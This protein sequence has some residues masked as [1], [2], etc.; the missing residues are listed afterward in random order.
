[1][2]KAAAGPAAL[3]DGPRNID[4]GMELYLYAHSKE[5]EEEVMHDCLL[6][7]RCSPSKC[8]SRRQQNISEGLPFKTS[9]PR[10]SSLPEEECA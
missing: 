3:T 7:V 1:M 6:F 4:N 10:L 2:A 8:K 5:E 9:P